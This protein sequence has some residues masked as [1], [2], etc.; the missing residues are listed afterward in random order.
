[1]T[2]HDD[3][4]PASARVEVDLETMRPGLLGYCDAVCSFFGAQGY[5]ADRDELSLVSGIA[6]QHYI[7]EPGYNRHEE[8]R[9]AHSQLA[10]LFN[11]YGF[12]ESLRYFTGWEVRDFDRIKKVDF[13]NLATWELSQGRA[14]L[15]ADVAGDLQPAV[16]VGYERVG[17]AQTLLAK[18]RRGGELVDETIDLTRRKNLQFDESFENFIVMVRPQDGGGEALVGPDRQRFDVLRW[19]VE[20]HGHDKEFFH[21]TRENYA[22]GDRGWQRLLELR[23]SAGPDDAA[24]LAEHLEML[25]EGRAAAARVL[26]VWAGRLGALRDSEELEARLAEAGQAYSAVAAAVAT[27][28]LADAREHER[29]AIQ[30]LADAQEWFPGKFEP[31]EG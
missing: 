12:F 2:F 19:T 8:P 3:K 16:I 26:K 10:L 13:W 9:R 29:E 31:L 1:M 5:E 4:I 23:D 25:T 7:Y 17:S 21:E 11:N 20:H 15:T 6:T 28:D 27:G 14:L 24:Y 18:R 30:R 22:P